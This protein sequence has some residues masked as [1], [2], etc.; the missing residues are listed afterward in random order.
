MKRGL[1]NPPDDIN[2]DIEHVFFASADVRYWV[3]MLR[4]IQGRGHLPLL[5]L[6]PTTDPN[7]VVSVLRGTQGPYLLRY[8]HEFNGTWYPWGGDTK[9]VN[10][11]RA[12]KKALPAG[13][14]LVWCPNIHYM[15]AYEMTNFW[16]G[17]NVVDI[18]GLDGYDQITGGPR[19]DAEEIFGPTM[20]MIRHELMSKR[21]LMICE[22][23]TPRDEGQP[24]WVRDLLR[25][26]NDADLSGIVYFNKD[27]EKPWALSQKSLHVFQKG[28]R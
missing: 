1:F 28:N 11:W 17:E 25:F 15:G 16:P 2:V 24:A 5:T 27:K 22:T 3:P 26:G 10:D 9:L 7:Y 20:E 4:A 13:A 21:P 23:A 18:I 14:K 19:L 6:L 8:A 12:I